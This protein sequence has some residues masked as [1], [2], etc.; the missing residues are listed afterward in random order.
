MTLVLST[1][2]ESAPERT[3]R[4]WASVLAVGGH[5]LLGAVILTASDDVR[6]PLPLA[7]RPMAV[8]FV[9]PSRPPAPEV[10][11]PVAAPPAP[12]VTPPKPL[13]P[14]RPSLT[15]VRAPARATAPAVVPV[16]PSPPTAAPAAAMNT[17]AAAPSATP[18]ASGPAVTGPAEPPPVVP[19]RFDAAYLNNPKPIYPPGAR[20]RGETGTVT[21]RV[22]V[23]ED[24]TAAQVEMKTGS[25]SPSL[26]RA[27]QEAVAQW[28]FV[29]A[30]QGGAPIRSWVLV[31]VSFSLS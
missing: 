26:D 3:T 8:R 23:A 20:R 5:V 2:V 31:P 10:A 28:R 9:A 7:T 12:V 6:P 29:P 24:G 14:S 19:A 13:R 17:A 1:L 11:P 15:P 18:A 21:L 16:P 25:G 27:A 22:L 4:L 30:R